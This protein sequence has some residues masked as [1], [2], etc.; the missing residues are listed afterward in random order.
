MTGVVSFSDFKK[1]DLRVGKVIE[2]EP[3]PNADKLYVLKVDLGEESPRT[4]VAGI[5]RWFKPEELVGKSVVVAANLEPAKIRGVLSQGML[6]VAEKDEKI[7]LL[8]VESEMPA[9]S[10]V[11]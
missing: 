1:V 7:S 8:S 9:G 10:R 4:V 5:V 3:H 11:M 2:A 6:L